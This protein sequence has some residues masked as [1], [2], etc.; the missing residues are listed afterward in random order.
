MSTITNRGTG[1]G[2]AGTNASGLP[3][4]ENTDLRTHY[5][6]IETHRSKCSPVRNY[7]NITF[8]SDPTNTVYI[9]SKK[10]STK[11]I[12][13]QLGYRNTNQVAIDGC[14]D[15]DETFLDE[16]RGFFF[17]IEKKKQQG[18][19]SVIEKLQGA[20]MKKLVYERM[21]PILEIKYVFCLSDWMRSDDEKN[22][23]TVA[24]ISAVLD[25]L[26]EH[27]IP[28]FW[29][30]DADYKERIIEYITNDSDYE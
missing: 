13:K 1:A 11:N 3:F 30:D 14:I 22:A 7:E 17:I 6:V 10:G 21:Y 16:A 18:S 5:T 9:S 26:T 25:I 2:G 19:G 15:P 4:E 29:G 27:G 24:K 12:M 28:V 8:N 20:L 23:N